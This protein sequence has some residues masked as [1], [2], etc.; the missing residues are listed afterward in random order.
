MPSRPA[1]SLR[2]T[3][4]D[5]LLPATLLLLLAGA[6][7]AYWIALRSATKA[8][9][10]SLLDT[11]FAISEQLQLADGRP[12]LQLSPQARTVLLT[13][14]FDQV[15]FSVRSGSGDLLDGNPGLPRLD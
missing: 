14:K 12:Q 4:I 7:A 15:Y 3:L 2:R 1:L 9:D 11:A 10:R 8:Y 5:R 13:D 6:V